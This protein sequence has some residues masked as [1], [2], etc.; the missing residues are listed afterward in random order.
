MSEMARRS[1]AYHWLLYLAAVILLAVV[2]R[3][4][5]NH[6][7][8]DVAIR[9]LFGWQTAARG[10]RRLLATMSTGVLMPTEA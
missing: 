10:T 7:G 3:P 9:A 8:H 2:L 4:P 5:M 1:T 6:L